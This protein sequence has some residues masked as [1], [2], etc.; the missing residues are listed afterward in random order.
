VGDL[1]DPALQVRDVV[2][3]GEKL[4]A[5]FFLAGPLFTTEGGHGTEF[6]SHMPDQIRQR[7]EGQ[8]L[9]MP[10]TAAEAKQMVDALKRDNVDAIKAVME[11]GAGGVVFNRLDPQILNAIGAA[12]HADNLPLLVHTGDPRDGGRAQSGRERHRARVVPATH[13]GSRLRGDGPEG[14]NLR[15][16]AQ[17]G[18]RFSEV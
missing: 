18:G 5:E 1:L 9:R 7:M 14:R 10:K 3:G 15:P 8:F 13:S 4:G 11:S 2:N 16:D 12:A 17:C 6:F